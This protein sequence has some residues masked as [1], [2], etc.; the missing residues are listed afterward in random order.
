MLERQL[1]F[2]D[3]KDH[4]GTVFTLYDD[5][6]PRAALR[7]DEATLL[8]AQFN[9]P[10]IRPGFSLIFVGADPKVLPQ[11]LYRLRHEGM[12]EIAIVLVPVGK[13]ER[14]VSYQAV[15]N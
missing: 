3:F 6:A 8:P 10:G 1:V 14:G 9:L 7:L 13:D 15:F 11:G 4:V 5:A 12:G 2:E